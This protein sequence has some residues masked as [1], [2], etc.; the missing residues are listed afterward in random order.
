MDFFNKAVEKL[1][2][3]SSDVA[4]KAKDLTGI[5]KL[6]SQIANCES[7][8]KATYAE[9]GIYGR[10]GKSEGRDSEVKGQPEVWPV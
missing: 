10:N 7:T 6:N 4:K 1:T 5:A 8:I 9:I 3:T 2:K